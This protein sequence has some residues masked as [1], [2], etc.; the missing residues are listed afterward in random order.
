MAGEIASEQRTLPPSVV[1][2]GDAVVIPDASREEAAMTRIVQAVTPLDEDD[3]TPSPVRA[4]GPIETPAISGAMLRRVESIAATRGPTPSKVIYASPEPGAGSDGSADP[5]R[6]G[7]YGGPAP[8]FAGQAQSGQA[9]S[10][11]QAPPTLADPRASMP[12]SAPRAAT[13]TPPRPALRNEITT[14]PS[15]RPEVL[16]PPVDRPP[17][18]TSSV[19]LFFGLAI[20]VVLTIAIG[21]IGGWYLLHVGRLMLTP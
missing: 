1:S 2:A 10:G 18:A 11:N 8:A 14:T 13:F 3:G 6:P 20:A 12:Q 17:A 7:Y 15:A 21:G 5:S 4:P 9:Q 19:G 16:D